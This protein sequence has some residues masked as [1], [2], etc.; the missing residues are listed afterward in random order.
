MKGLSDTKILDSVFDKRT[1]LTIHKMQDQGILSSIAGPISTGKEANVYEGRA[2]TKAAGANAGTNTAEAKAAE[3]KVAIKIYRIETSN[4]KKMAL[5]LHADPRFS[6]IKHDL[7]STIYACVQKEF[8]NLQKAFS[9]GIHCP[10]P[11][12]YKN[13]VI[14]MD[15]IGDEKPAPM[16]KDVQLDNATA[17]QLYS[18][19]IQDLT[20]LYQKAELVHADASEYN[21]LLRLS[22]TTPYLIDFSQAVLK[23]HPQAHEYLVR[24]I[25]NL[26]NFFKKNG[27]KTLPE[28]G[29]FQDIKSLK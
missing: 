18:L 4:Y 25:K 16:L 17:A 9:K 3:S 27:V 5:Y 28:K 24:D 6:N 22:D 14:I 19:V 2:G 1:L 7:K 20:T 10:R 26:T 8:R 29:V 11:L 12:A 21:T 15:L 13:N 23:T